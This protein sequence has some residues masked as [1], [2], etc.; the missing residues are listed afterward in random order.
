[1]NSRKNL[2]WWFTIAFVGLAIFFS[3]I[4]QESDAMVAAELAIVFALLHGDY[5]R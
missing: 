3:I 5:P 2:M 1:M 4:Q